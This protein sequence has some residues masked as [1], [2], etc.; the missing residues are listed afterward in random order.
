MRK[1]VG[2]ISVVA[3]I[4]AVVVAVAI[5]NLGS[6]LNDNKAW[7]VEQIEAAVERPVDFDSVG[8][9]FSRGLAVTVGGFRIGEDEAFG[10]G[11]FLNVGAAE[12]RV[13]LWPALFG[14]IVVNKISFRDVSLVV[15]QTEGGL[16]TD[17]V[18]GTS[19]PTDEPVA[20]REPDTGLNEQPESSPVNSFNVALAE[21]RSGRLQF[22]DRS[23][24]PP[25]EVVVEQ[26][27]FETRN[28]G[29]TKP[30]DFQ[31]S[32]ELLGEEDANVR[33]VGSVG[34]FAATPKDQTPVDLTFSLNPIV[35]EQLRSL[36]GMADAIDPNFPLD[37]TMKVSGTLS[38]SVENPQVALSF[39][40]T[41]AL[42]TYAEDGR[43]DRGVPL[44]LDF[45]VAM[46]GKDIEISSAEFKFEGVKLR[47]SGT[48]QNVDDPSVDLLVEV[49]GGQIEIDGGWNQDGVLDLTANID[50]LELGEVASALAQEAAMVLDGQLSMALTVTGNG[51]TWE[52]IKPGLEG[53]G[54]A[55]IEGAV[56]HDINLMEEVL[57]G[58][59]GIPG[60][61]G[62][63]SSKLADKYPTL[64]ST[65]DTHFKSM[66]GKV[67]VREGRVQ[68]L[69]VEFDAKDFGMNGWGSVSLD[70]E[71]DLNT[72]LVF[73]ERLS[74]D[75][76]DEA[77][78]LRYLR[79][80]TG[81]VE[82]PIAITGAFP[83][84]SAR[85]DTG[86]IAKKLG[87]GATRDMVKKSLGKFTKKIKKKKKKKKKS[88]IPASADDGR[89]LLENLLP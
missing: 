77:K 61:S 62:Q 26:L 31:F 86:A 21:I 2:A 28:F 12:L 45:D 48:V 41:D 55:K 82:L 60:L 35:V 38:G 76:I 20:T 58:L 4:L 51:T 24:S 8:V 5:S 63:L 81:L 71:V 9:S 59:T 57:G 50:G 66:Q 78:L 56:L 29:L 64:F 15:I 47:A 32:G 3:V 40:G 75:L 89:D 34:P 30:L 11:D 16:S 46:K 44:G 10:D 54:S 22:I 27:E 88:G 18:G 1:W 70:G 42:V 33:I 80:E 72:R 6:W 67:E 87:G 73:A 36:P 17:S 53:L 19:E 14:D 74:E 84:I 83:D 52:E 49:F 13:A 37:G 43:K 68:I 39:D 7:I 85:P 69:G 65:G 23:V 25:A 79:G